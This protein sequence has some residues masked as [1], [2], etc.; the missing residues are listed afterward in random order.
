MFHN[1]PLKVVSLVLALFF[2]FFVVSLESIYIKLTAEIPVTAFNK[3]EQ[4]AL[5][6]PLPII[7]LG[8]RTDDP[9]LERSLT[10]AD[11]E[12]Y[13]DLSNISVGQHTLPVSVTS[14][15]AHVSVVHVEPAEVTVI[16]EQVK[17]KYISL[18]AK[19]VGQPARGFTVRGVDISPKSVTVSGAESVLKRVVRGEVRVEVGANA[20]DSF[21]IDQAP[22]IFYDANDAKIDG[23]TFEG[24]KISASVEIEKSNSTK[25]VGVH[26]NIKGSAANM[27]VKEI[28]VDPSL[29]TIEG[30]PDVIEKI[31]TLE[32]AAIDI[33]G[34]K[35]DVNR[36]IAIV[37]PAGVKLS[38]G[39]PATVTV[40]IQFEQTLP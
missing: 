11:F 33:T 12:A 29:I 36:K 1:F 26:P 14:R 18:T 17:Q 13:I 19:T 34:A 23:V 4:V 35:K 37:L 8:I 32:S 40:T 3:G 9:L 31:E 39:S 28:L 10:A 21:V 5:T 6:T 27:T 20:K 30:A 15:N 38:D 25:Q 2:W 22:V 24:Q 7:K 16:L